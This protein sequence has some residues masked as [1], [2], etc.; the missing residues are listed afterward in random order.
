MQKK[1]FMPVL[2]SGVLGVTICAIMFIKGLTFSAIGGRSNLQSEI[3]IPTQ[4]TIYLVE[5]VN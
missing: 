3:S 5:K 4:Q 2:D 1:F